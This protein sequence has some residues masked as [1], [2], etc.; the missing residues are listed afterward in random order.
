MKKEKTDMCFRPPSVTREYTCPNCG[1]IVSMNAIACYKCGTPMEEIKAA[2][3]Q[4]AAAQAAENKDT[5]TDGSAPDDQ[6][7]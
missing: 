5:A 1:T 4:A 2:K 7:A 6:Q 3:E